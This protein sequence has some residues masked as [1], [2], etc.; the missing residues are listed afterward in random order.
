MQISSLQLKFR[1]FFL[2]K[3]AKMR[4]RRNIV[5]TVCDH[6]DNIYTPSTI[7]SLPLKT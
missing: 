2:T 5:R 4:A 3:D 7:Y 1:E 6:W